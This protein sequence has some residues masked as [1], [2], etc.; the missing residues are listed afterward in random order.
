MQA[1]FPQVSTDSG[2]CDFPAENVSGNAGKEAVQTDG[3]CKV[4]V[5]WLVKQRLLNFFGH[6]SKILRISF[7]AQLGLARKS[8]ENKPSNQNKFLTRQKM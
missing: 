6:T 1:F 3:R 5:V 7:Y 8:Y 2:H 4:R